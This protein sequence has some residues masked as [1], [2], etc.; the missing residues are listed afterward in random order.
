MPPRNLLWLVAVTILP[1][2]FAAAILCVATFISFTNPLKTVKLKEVIAK[3]HPNYQTLQA[4]AKSEDE[5]W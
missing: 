4:R 5:A 2:A 3:Q 1:L